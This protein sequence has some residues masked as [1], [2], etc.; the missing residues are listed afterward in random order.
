MD[1]CSG[2][3]PGRNVPCS[4]LNEGLPPAGQSLSDAL[5]RNTHQVLVHTCGQSSTY[6][7]GRGMTKKV[8]RV[9]GPE[10]GEGK[11]ARSFQK[12]HSMNNQNNTITKCA[13]LVTCGV[14]QAS[15]AARRF[16]TGR[17]RR[18]PA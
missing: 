11:N 2:L 10:S 7:H 16:T 14:N 8:F 4:K 1:C 12:R 18:R 9:V 6:V 15:T 17:F 3:Q 5:A 13:L